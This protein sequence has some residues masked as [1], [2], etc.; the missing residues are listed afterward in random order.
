MNIEKALMKD[1]KDIEELYNEAIT[2]LYSKEIYQW[3]FTYPNKDLYKS[4]IKDGNMYLF[5]IDEKLI[6][7]AILDEE[8]SIEWNIIDWKYK[9]GKYLVIHALVV[10]PK[11]QGK[12]YGKQILNMCEKIAIDEGYKSIRLDVFP[13]NSVAVKLYENNDYEKAG[14][15]K[16]DF[17]PVDKERFYCY[18][19]KI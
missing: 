9:E 18:E 14:E 15:V 2:T 1:L 6:G 8:Q 4:S 17:K 11:H 13:E 10:E 16:Y 3:N 5:K 19:K 7:A 12:G